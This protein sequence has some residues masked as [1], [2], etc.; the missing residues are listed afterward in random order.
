[1]HAKL[2]ASFKLWWATVFCI[3]YDNQ[4]SPHTLVDAVSSTADTSGNIQLI[5]LNTSKVGVPPK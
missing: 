5:N 2:W 3:V 4:G 1:M